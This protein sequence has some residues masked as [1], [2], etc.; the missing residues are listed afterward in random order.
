MANALAPEALRVAEGG[1][2]TARVATS[3][4]CF[5]CMLGGTDGTTLFAMTAPTS[6]AALARHSKDAR[7]EVAT[8][9]VPRAGRP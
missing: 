3:Q 4:T 8:V 9:A 1:E 2:I 6:N 5:A 7:I